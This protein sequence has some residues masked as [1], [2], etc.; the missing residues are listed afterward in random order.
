MARLTHS[1]LLAGL[2]GIVGSDHLSTTEPDRVAYSADFWPKAQIWKLGGD[3]C[4]FPPDAIVWPGDEAEVAAILAL[5]HEHL[6]PVIPYGGGSGVCGGTI[7]IHGGVIV[8]TKRLNRVL[9]FD[10]ASATITAEAG[11]NGMHLEDRL[12]A[13]G[14]TLGHFPSS[15]MCSTLGGWLAARSAGQYSS[16]YGKIEDMV[17]SLRM[18][19]P[20]G[21][22]LDTAERGPGEPDWNQLLVGAEGTLGLITSATLA[23]SP[24]PEARRL[25]AF[26]FRHLADGLRGARAIMQA[27]LKPTVLRLYDPFDSLI[28]LGKESGDEAGGRK[29][30]LHALRDLLSGGG[31]AGPARGRRGLLSRHLGDLGRSLKRTALTT[32]LSSPSLINGLASAVPSPCLLIFGFEGPADAIHADAWSA[33]EL[34]TECGGTDAGA[35]LGEAWL[36][37]RYSVSFK[38][39]KLYAMGAFVD[40]ME[41]ATTWDRLEGLYE[42]VKKVL[43]PHVFVMAHFSHAYREGCSVYFTF[44]GYRRDARR[45]EQHYDRVWQIAMDAVHAAGGT[46]SHHHGVGM[47]KMSAMPRE[48]GDGLAVW[49]ALKTALDP[50]G[51]MN[52]GKL[53]PE[54]R[55]A[56]A[57]GAEE[58]AP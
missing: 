18:A 17:L 35:G 50:H 9:G 42:R 28:A 7:P 33:S 6:I 5:C 43:A 14:M 10:A 8:D 46:T 45:A 37:H 36:A 57:E 27:G 34:L 21:R 1:E 24:L 3:A 19:L 58:L 26:R 53:F 13:R 54:D 47:S 29:S 12:N 55:A 32:A 31:A 39:S 44:A 11:I 23:V 25:R 20:D 22:V 2:E 4:R 49:R 38:Q 16:R 56:P 52:P 41:V 15:I 48:H 30:L 51:V 40:T